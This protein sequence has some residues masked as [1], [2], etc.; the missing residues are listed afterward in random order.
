MVGIGPSS[1][2]LYDLYGTHSSIEVEV[3]TEFLWLQWSTN[4]KDAKDGVQGYVQ[5]KD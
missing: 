4:N 3:N 5:R 2:I 1:P